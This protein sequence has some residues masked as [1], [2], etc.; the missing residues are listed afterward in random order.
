MASAGL[1]R[2]LCAQNVLHQVQLLRIPLERCGGCFPHDAVRR[3]P[4]YDKE[5]AHAAI[6]GLQKFRL[7]LPLPIASR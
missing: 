4:R 3:D 6:A 5:G 2:V 7:A 1:H